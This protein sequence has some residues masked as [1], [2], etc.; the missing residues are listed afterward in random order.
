MLG[1]NLGVLSKALLIG[2]I[3]HS[4]NIF[5]EVKSIEK[6]SLEFA[7]LNYEIGKSTLSQVLEEIKSG[8]L[9]KSGDAGALMSKICFKNDEGVFIVFESSEMGG[10]KMLITSAIVTKTPM[11]TNYKC[12]NHVFKSDKI[13]LDSQLSLGMTLDRLIKIKGKPTTRSKNVLKYEK[14]ADLTDKGKIVQSYSGFTYYFKSNK[15]EKFEIFK[16]E[17]Y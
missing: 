8:V 4:V 13:F 10:E 11:P 15:L 12:T 14:S 3:F 6:T 5:G 2:I 16:I 17:S 9:I 1:H 7:V